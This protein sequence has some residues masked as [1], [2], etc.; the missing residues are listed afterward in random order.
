M[1]CAILSI[2]NELLIGQVI[3][4]N[5]AWLGEQLTDLGWEITLH[6]AVGD[7][8]TAIVQHLNILSENCDVL[9]TTGGL[10]PTRD[11]ITKKALAEVL[12]VN[13]YFHE[14]TWEKISAYFEKR[15]YPISELHRHQCFM[16]EGTV[17]LENQMGTAPG[18]QAVH[19][20][21]TIFVLPGVPYEMK[22]LT[23]S[24]VLPYL[25]NRSGLEPV[26]KHTFYTAGTGETV[27]AD[28]ITEFETSLPEGYSIAYLPS[29]GQVRV[30]LNGRG[31]PDIFTEKADELRSYLNK[32]LFGE[33]NTSLETRL[34]EILLSKNLQVATAESCT[35]GSIG[36]LITSVP[37]SS[38]YF[39]GSI[40]AYHND[41]KTN[42]LGVD[43]QI[44]AH[45][46][47]VSAACVE[48]MVRGL[49]PLLKADVGI[50]VSGIAGPDGGTPEKP[51]G[52]IWIAVGNRHHIKSMCIQFNKDRLRN[53]NFTVIQAINALRL[54]VLETYP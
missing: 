32:W 33:G 14:P 11:D 46:G 51:V 27:I 41:V 53:I 39:R 17:I 15:K 34:G 42:L 8:H 37:G 52:T 12:G 48:A 29:L 38:R 24:H 44:L 19:G 20:D 50:A 2:G 18:L 6:C 3:N 43:T 35:G 7:D 31:N 47:A 28:H 1:R 45:E 5:A 26:L 22:H 13:L 40:V 21:C 9:I 4:T 49:L 16:P 23:E 10:G 30:R 25:K 54:F 36:A